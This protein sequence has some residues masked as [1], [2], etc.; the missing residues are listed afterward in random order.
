[1]HF[2]L[3]E[4]HRILR[5][6]VRA[7]AE[8]EIRPVA[9]ELDDRE[10][11]SVDLT[12][13]MGELG[14]FGIVVPEE[15]GGQ[16][17]NALA[18]IIAIE[19]LARV[20]GSQAATV[21]AG[22][23]LG[24]GAINAYGSEQQK[25]KYLPALCGGKSL[26]GFALTE[27]GAGSDL[28]SIQTR[29]VESDRGWT[30]NGSKTFTTNASSPISIGVSVLAVTGGHGREPELS[31]FLAEHGT[32]GFEA[33]TMHGKL[34]WRASD[35]AELSFT[36]CT[37]PS[38]AILGTRGGGF[39]AALETLDAGRLGIAAMGLGAAQGAFEAALAHAKDRTQFARP[40]GKFQGVSF[41][42]ADMSTQ[43]EHARTFLYRAAWLRDTGQDFRASA[44]MAKLY[45]TE[46]AGRVTDA[47][48]QIH[49]GY[50]LM[51]DSVVERFYRDHRILRIGEGTSEI[52][53]VVI[54]RALG[55]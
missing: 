6:T 44:A 48:V 4:E 49:G 15:Y 29:A 28:R 18:S 5:D 42:L 11:F 51:K 34:G 53:R 26:W 8:S 2:E 14:L 55:L 38:D 20:D 12:K 13:K 22:N 32:P 21:A 33:V 19:E 30:L 43:I 41:Q 16:G 24:I 7:F 45:C 25:R 54:A 9:R 17:M 37:V 1:M 31:L 23:A 39:Q 3:S 46:V 52:Q 40:I 10:E 50:G 36:D 27:P 47:A 35:T